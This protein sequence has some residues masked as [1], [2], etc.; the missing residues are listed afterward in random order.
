MIITFLYHNYF[1]YCIIIILI[2]LLYIF[3]I[4]I[5]L[6]YIFIVLIVFRVYTNNFF[7]LFLSLSYIYIGSDTPGAALAM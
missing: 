1:I 4:L 5:V 2:V 3:I 7:L 6:L